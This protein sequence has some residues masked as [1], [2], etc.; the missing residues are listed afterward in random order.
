MHVWDLKTL[1]NKR[2]FKGYHKHDVYLLKFT[3]NDK[4]LIACG[5]RLSTPVIIY[6]IEDGSIVLSTQVRE[7]VRKI[8]TVNNLIG[9]FHSL[10]GY[11]EYFLDEES[12]LESSRSRA[13]EFEVLVDKYFVLI[14]ATGFYFFQSNEFGVYETR[15]YLLA[16][17]T[18]DMDLIN[19]G[20]SFLINRENPKLR[21]YADEEQ[22]T[23]VLLTGHRDGKVLVWN[24]QQDG[25]AFEKV[26]SDYKH[27]IIEIVQ[28][29]SGI[30]IATEDSFIH[31]WDLDLKNAL[32]YIDLSNMPLKL[33]S[34]KLKNLVPA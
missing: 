7:F 13:G 4:F 19:C 15:E 25:I 12:T 29:E 9:G 6:N 28:L 2:V 21:A 30:G 3:N 33:Y 24:M 26:L 14:S 22:K 10:L 32:K 27:E 18:E 23:L 34:L 8:V 5:K 16:D 1:K 20:S 31:L 11:K 17:Y